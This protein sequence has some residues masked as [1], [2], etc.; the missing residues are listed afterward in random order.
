MFYTVL[1]CFVVKQKTVYEM[2]ISDCSSDVC[3]SDLVSVTF[4][5][6]A[7]FVSLLKDERVRAAADL[8]SL[9]LMGTGSAAIP[10][11]AIDGIERE[12]GI[13]IINFIGSNRANSRLSTPP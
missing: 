4:M 7:F 5:P 3:S 1:C 2:R 11:W 10:A 12:F 6:P 13:E 9:R 8:S